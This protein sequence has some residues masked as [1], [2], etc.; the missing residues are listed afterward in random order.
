MDLAP[1]AEPLLDLTPRIVELGTPVLFLIGGSD[2]LY[3]PAEVEQIAQRLDADH[4]DHE[5]IVYPDTPHGF[6]CHERD[7]YSPQAAEDAFARLTG[8][9]SRTVPHPT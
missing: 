2:H 9:F 7:T 3:G 4:L 5:M 8:L 1:A 6:F